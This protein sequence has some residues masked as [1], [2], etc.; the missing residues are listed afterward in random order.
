L[1]PTRLASIFAALFGAFLGLALLKFGNPPIMETWVEPP[2]NI[3]ELVFGSLWPIAWAYRLLGL[4]AI[5]GVIVAAGT[6]SI[7]LDIPKW[8]VALPVLWLA[9]QVL[10][11]AR[12]VDDQLSWPTLKHF[13]ACVVCFYLGL[14]SLARVRSLRLFWLGLFVAFLIVL[15]IGW[16]QHFGGLEATRQYFFREIYPQ[17]K[18]VSPEYLKKIS[19][20]RIFSTL[21]YPNSL[22]GALLLLLP[23][24]LMLV[25]RAHRLLTLP[26]R[27]FLA[28]LIG[29]AALACLFWSGSKGGWLLMLLLA[30]LA[31]LRLPFPRSLKLTLLGV[32]LAVGLS[33]FLWKY[34]SFFQKGATSVSARFD[35]WEAALK[36]AQ[37]NPLTGTG[38]GTFSIPYKALKHPQ[39][40]M[41]RLVHNDYLE[42]ASD[43]GWLGFWLYTTFIVEAMF[44]AIKPPV[45]V[46]PDVALSGQNPSKKQRK[47]G[48]RALDKQK[49]RSA[50]GSPLLPAEADPEQ[51]GGWWRFSIWLGLLGWA[52]QGLF[53][54]GLYI[55][56]LSWS[57]FT[58][59]GLLLGRTRI[60]STNPGVG[61]NLPARHENPVPERA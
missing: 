45:P 18:V 32:V 53:D 30:L 2:T 33:G 58:F 23:V 48:E 57:A 25:G 60:P 28:G 16:E 20:N 41:T 15:T 11:A 14:F 36:T 7:R 61:P 50:Q 17:L 52:L 37:V 54:F 9:C 59:L 49:S 19:S 24:M 1:N 39:S 21:F 6:G 51:A 4:V 12:S 55:P 26:A 29:I 56:A 47:P 42:Q 46:S 27:C 8:L 3:Y 43:S 38:P 31:L 44:F 10:A 35:Y 22:A 13:V 34:I 40:E 5:L